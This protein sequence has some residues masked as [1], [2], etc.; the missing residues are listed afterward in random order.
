MA[1]KTYPKLELR[2]L[3]HG[4]NVCFSYQR[5]HSNMTRDI[6][7]ALNVQRFQTIA[8]LD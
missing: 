7:D 4:H 5:D 8:M 2:P 3:F 1:M 6:T